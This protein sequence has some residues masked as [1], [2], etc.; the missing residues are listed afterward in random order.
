LDTTVY[1]V[2]HA[3]PDYSIRDDR[4]RPLTEKGRLD[5]DKVTAALKDRDITAVYSSPYRRAVETVQGVADALGVQVMTVEDFRERRVDNAWIE[6]FQ[7]FARRQWEDFH[8]KL[9]GGESLA[10]VQARNVAAL[11]EILARHPGQSLVVGTHGTAMSTLLRHIRPAFG[12][13][14][15]WGLVNRMPCI[16]RLTFRSGIF[17]AC[18]EIEL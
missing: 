16:F 17:Q 9:D 3:Q 10:E 12:F 15:F 13:D 18:M 14:D 11:S 4:S 1:L 8:Y 7:A 2:R 6:D 5:T